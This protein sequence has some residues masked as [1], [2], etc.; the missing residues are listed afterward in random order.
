[1]LYSSLYTSMFKFTT[2]NR[3]DLSKELCVFFVMITI[4]ITISYLSFFF[5]GQE[6]YGQQ[7]GQ[8]LLLGGDDDNNQFGDGSDSIPNGNSGGGEGGSQGQ[9]QG[10]GGFG[11][12]NGGSTGSF[13]TYENPT[14]GITMQY[15]SN[16]KETPAPQIEG[17][18][19]IVKLI[20]DTQEAYVEVYITIF[21]YDLS[22]QVTTQ[23]ELNV[24]NID[25]VQR[26]ARILDSGPTTISGGNSAYYF[27][28]SFKNQAE[29]ALAI[30]TIMNNKEYWIQFGALPEIYDRYLPIG[31]QMI[32][33][34]QIR[35]TSTGGERESPG[36]DTPQQQPPLSPSTPEP[37]PDDTQQ[38]PTSPI[39]DQEPVAPDI[40]MSP[41]P[42]TQSDLA[43]D[44]SDV[45]ALNDKGYELFDSGRYEE[46]IEYFDRAL[47]IEPANTDI[48]INKGYALISL[49][50]YH[51]AIT[52]LDKALAIEPNDAYALANKGYA[53]LSLHRYKEAIEYFDRALAIE[54][55]DA[56]A[57]ARKGNA[58]Y[59][60]ARYEEAIIYYDKALAIDPNNAYTLASKGD[61]LSQLGK[62]NEAIEYFDRA[63]AINSTDTYALFGKGVSLDSLNRTEEAINYYDKVLAI[64]ST[65]TYALNNKGY[66]LINLGRIDE[67][68]TYLDKGLLIDPNDAFI[69][70]NKGYALYKLGR[71]EEAITYFD[72]AL[73]IDPTLT[74]ALHDKDLVLQVIRQGNLTNIEEEQLLPQQEGQQPRRIAYG[75]PQGDTP[76]IRLFHE[77]FAVDN[78]N[79]KIAFDPSTYQQSSKYIE[80]VKAAINRWSEL[81]KQYSGN[82]DAWNFNVITETTTTSTSTTTSNNEDTNTVAYSTS[83]TANNNI[84]PTDIVV[85]VKGDP[86]AN[87]CELYGGV[88]Y[89]HPHDLQEVVKSKVLTSCGQEEYDQ[90]TVYGIVLHEFGHN[91]GLGHAYNLHGDLM[92]SSDKDERGE[93]IMTCDP[94]AAADNSGG[95]VEPSEQDINAVLYKY[96]KDGFRQPNQALTGEKPYYLVGTPIG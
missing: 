48:L 27:E 89:P 73:A 14:Y 47:A 39:I 74:E 34:V 11:F 50:R 9:G 81:L 30:S 17:N 68:I 24:Q 46:A 87:E 83:I 25:F 59:E 16:W 18:K 51:E 10:G 65:D 23:E 72:R 58:L 57:L 42:R 66:S 95:G 64:N 29:H 26:N 49:D 70:D 82:Y 12:P 45:S 6:V 94:A 93:R 90:N 21:V 78:I 43:I 28:I 15:P 3:A 67:A 2:F 31:E 36:F 53:L 38:L 5:S 63:L 71:Y 4:I 80:V 91:L 75:L 79:V 85:E 54:P 60:T 62:D 52:Y 55:D 96:G 32:S 86:Q 40:I 92:C 76:F 77:E 44:P 13:L 20:P 19:P 84:P 37:L 35:S 88:A 8:Q 1:M 61:A 22:P 7:S 33:S 41:P 56:Y 69:L